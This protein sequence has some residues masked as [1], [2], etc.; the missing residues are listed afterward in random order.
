MKLFALLLL[1][2]ALLAADF[3]AEGKLWWSHVQ[4]LA[5][6]KLEGR[7][8]GSEGFRKAV[9]YVETA[10]ER[11]GLK[12]AGTSGYQ[13]PVKFETRTILED[14]SSLALVRGDQVQPLALGQDAS[15]NSRAS[16]APSVEAPMVFVG[17]GMS[18]PEIHYNEL[19]G[20]DLRG[21]IAVYVNAGGP[22][23]APGNLKSHHS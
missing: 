15:F 20:I 18:L 6:D 8:T 19:D 5:D 4:F 3:A 1:S 23:D 16:L 7:N 13:Q 14:L 12:P 2:T 10:F 22:V 17:Y 21:K 9:E 11:L